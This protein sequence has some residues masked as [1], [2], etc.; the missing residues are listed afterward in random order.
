MKK[1]GEV[2][3]HE[4]GLALSLFVEMPVPSQENVCICVLGI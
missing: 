3:A 4:T 2:L 1:R